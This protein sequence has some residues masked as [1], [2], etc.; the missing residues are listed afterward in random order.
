MSARFAIAIVLIVSAGFCWAQERASSHHSTYETAQDLSASDVLPEELLQGEH[1]VVDDRV[2]NDGYLNYYTI[3]SD[4]GDFEAAS[5]AI[6]RIR[7]REVAALAE[8][9]ELS[10]TK[11][12][13]KAMA[14]AGVQR[15]VGV[16]QLVMHP[17]QTAKGL[18]SGIG[19]MFKRYSRKSKEAAAATKEYMTKDSGDDAT[20]TEEEGA[21]KTAQAISLTERYFGVTAAERKWC[22]NLRVDPYSSNEILRK[23][24]G[25]V[26][27]A[28]S[29]GKT[30]V[31]LAGMAIPYVGYVNTVSEAVWSEDIY[32]LRDSNRAALLATGADEALVDEY[33]TSPWLSPT[34][35]TL[36]TAAIVA[37][38]NVDGR[39][40]ILWQALNARGEIE[41]GYLVRA[42]GLLA[43]YHRNQAPFASVST[44]LAIPGG[45]TAEGK[46]VLL[47]PS[48]HVY[49]TEQMAEAAAEYHEV[50]RNESEHVREIWILG[51]TSDR[52]AEELLALGYD[53]HT[54]FGEMVLPVSDETEATQ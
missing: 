32:A 38:D 23:A 4:Y 40:G 10:Q 35:Q 51:T 48:D 12:F 8:L 22:K 49:W 25:N 43:W 9:D 46:S 29:L 34:Q 28:D 30:T 33:L 14:D 2:M 39:D 15:I 1:Y 13:I 54:D 21:E 3:R 27:R 53:L 44:E 26:A 17:I 36:L 6:L 5:T 41:V 37:L 50:D 20:A 42:A 18:P 31:L 11:V 47:F 19:R 7:I 16:Q 52:A 45:V 24:I